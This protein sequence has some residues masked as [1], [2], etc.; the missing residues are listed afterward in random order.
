[1]VRAAIAFNVLLSMVVASPTGPHHAIACN[2]FLVSLWFLSA[3]HFSGPVDGP[4]GMVF[5]IGE[6]CHSSTAAV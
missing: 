6:L 3:R 2:I 5:V 4:I 1:M